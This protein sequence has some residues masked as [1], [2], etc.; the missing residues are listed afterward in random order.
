MHNATMA[1]L[2]KAAAKELEDLRCPPRARLSRAASMSPPNVPLC[3][4]SSYSDTSESD[5]E[6][7]AGTGVTGAA[8]GEAG[9][10][11]YGRRNTVAVT[12]A[13]TGGCSGQRFP[14][15]CL[16]LVRSLPGNSR[17]VDCGEMSPE[18]ASISYGVLLCLRC[19]GRHRGHGINVSAAS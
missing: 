8:G 1:D 19:S 9:R 16:K 14:P 2:V 5:A 17:C 4:E 3:D 11:G 7:T 10:R 13:A 12:E 15:N 6:P 18:W